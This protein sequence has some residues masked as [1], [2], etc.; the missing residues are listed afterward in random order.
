MKVTTLTIIVIST[1]GAKNIMS[2]IV[3]LMLSFVI[4]AP[5]SHPLEIMLCGLTDLALEGS[6]MIVGHMHGH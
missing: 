1:G 5:G 3:V 2:F 4:G 6:Y